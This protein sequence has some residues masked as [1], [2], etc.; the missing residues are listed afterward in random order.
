MKFLFVF[1]L[2]HLFI[3][4]TWGTDVELLKDKLKRDIMEHVRGRRYDIMEKSE[5]VEDCLRLMQEEIL[6]E[7]N[8]QRDYDQYKKYCVENDEDPQDFINS[9]ASDLELE[10]QNTYS[11]WIQYPCLEENDRI[12]ISNGE[13]FIVDK[14]IV[15][16][17]VKPFTGQE[18]LCNLGVYS[19]KKEN[20][21]NSQWVLKFPQDQVS[22][23]HELKTYEDFKDSKYVVDLIAKEVTIGENNYNAFVMPKLIVRKLGDGE[24]I[25]LFKNMI[26]LLQDVIKRNYFLGDIE[27]QNFGYNE[28]ENIFQ[29]F[30]IGV[31]FE[32]PDS[33]EEFDHLKNTVLKNLGFRKEEWEGN[34]EFVLNNPDLGAY[35]LNAFDWIRNKSIVTF[36]DSYC[37]WEKKA[38]DFYLYSSSC[39]NINDVEKCKTCAGNMKKQL[40]KYEEDKLENELNEDF[41][42]I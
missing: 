22:Y 11:E 21:P 27:W 12:K 39:Y 35:H 16:K 31:S 23:D 5:D 18:G 41:R 2:A 20:D 10:F 9:I 29:V 8:H 28:N 6:K 36:V 13:E 40:E 19:L 17:M 26:G 3:V 38:I 42:K 1:L 7:L 30:D 25:I 37:F 4:S 33:K 24:K 34:V 32:I 15:P 14:I